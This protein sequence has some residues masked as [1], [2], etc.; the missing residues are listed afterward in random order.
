MQINTKAKRNAQTKTKKRTVFA[1]LVVQEGMGQEYLF[2]CRVFFAIGDAVA[3]IGVTVV[4]MGAL[5]VTTSVIIN[6][7]RLTTKNTSV[8][9]LFTNKF[10]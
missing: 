5:A 3:F 1:S 8:I 4:S 2:I 9:I 7:Q 6:N 10:K